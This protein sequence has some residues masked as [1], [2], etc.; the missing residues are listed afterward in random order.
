MVAKRLIILLVKPNQIFH[1]TRCITPNHVGL[2]G[3]SPHHCA[4][5]YNAA[6]FDQMLQRWRAVGDTMS[7]LTGPIFETQTFPLQ[8]RTRHSLDQRHFCDDVTSG[9]NFVQRFAF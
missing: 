5:L 9:L 1:Y 3:P 2:Q 4:G 6:P 8:R 7:D